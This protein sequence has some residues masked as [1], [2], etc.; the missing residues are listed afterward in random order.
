MPNYIDTVESSGD[1]IRMV[2]ERI[3]AQRSAEVEELGA[4]EDRRGHITRIQQKDEAKKEIARR[5]KHFIVNQQKLKVDYLIFQMTRGGE[6]AQPKTPDPDE[7]WY[8][9]QW[10][11]RWQ[12]GGKSSGIGWKSRMRQ[13]KSIAGQH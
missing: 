2:L 6:A 4:N 8:K 9:R 10:E 7:Q 13:R 11:R 3:D 5:K 1:S 12:T